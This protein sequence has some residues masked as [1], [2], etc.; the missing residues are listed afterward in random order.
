M[1][2]SSVSRFSGAA[3]SPHTHAC[4]RR[5][6]LRRGREGLL[7]RG[8]A[9]AQHEGEPRSAF[10]CTGVFPISWRMLLL[11]AGAGQSG[12]RTQ[13]PEGVR[14]GCPM[15]AAARLLGE[16]CCWGMGATRWLGHGSPAFSR[17]ASSRLGQL[18]ATRRISTQE[19][20]AGL[21]RAPLGTTSTD[22]QHGNPCPRGPGAAF[23]LPV[24][25]PSGR[26][27]DMLLVGT[28]TEPSQQP[29]WASRGLGWRER[30][31]TCHLCS[32]SSGTD[33]REPTL[34]KA[35]PGCVRPFFPPFAPCC[36]AYGSWPVA[37]CCSGVRAGD[38]S[39]FL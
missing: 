8:P 15:T 28:P 23:R 4:L 20:W 7:W 6:S 38:P 19:H 12:I 32:P 13:K 33:I 29:Q 27:G 17:S 25:G 37:A 9:R 3:R 10:P 39:Q 21:Q 30:P 35:F 2:I 26:V 5:W 22:V 18:G 14:A 16:D 31:D 11:P 1:E 36:P 24:A 34:C